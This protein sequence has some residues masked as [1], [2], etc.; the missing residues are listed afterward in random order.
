MCI[1][2]S[3]LVAQDK[4][5][6]QLFDRKGKAIKYKKMIKKL[7]E[8]ELILFG[9][10]HNNPI[11]HWLQFEITKDLYAKKTDSLVL[12][13][14]M[15]EADNQ[16][17]V[18]EYLQGQ[19]S[20]KNFQAEARLWD[21]YETDYKPLLEFAKAHGLPF[22]ASNIPRRYASLVYKQ[23]IE[24]LDS[25]SNEARRYIAPL[26]ITIDL[27]L[28]TYQEMLNMMGGHGDT[29]SANF[30][31]SQAT[32]DATMAYRI[33]QQLRPERCFIHYNGSYHSDYDEGIGWYIRH[34]RPDTKIITI[35]TVSQADVSKL[36]EEHQGK[37]DYIICVP[38]TMTTTY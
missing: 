38:E 33:T 30:P 29:A 35:T 24:Q 34:Y 6:Y 10:L 21:N 19:I 26:P 28:K 1:C 27:S 2:L 8:A 17:I 23:G 3:A 18:D 31:K 13:A 20:Q 25:L 5:A 14:E 12:G 15:F 11:A 7:P 22:V 16:L 37:A 4:P 9:E 32:K 36:E